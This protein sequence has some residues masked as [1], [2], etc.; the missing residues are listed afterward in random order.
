MI[1][2]TEKHHSKM[3]G[4]KIKQTLMFKILFFNPKKK[5][6][7]Q[8]NKPQSVCVMTSIAHLYKIW[9]FISIAMKHNI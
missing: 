6:Q 8:E 1:Q 2:L 7:R 4:K 9:K 3:K 5:N